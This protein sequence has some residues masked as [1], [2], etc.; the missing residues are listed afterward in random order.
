MEPGTTSPGAG[1]A[2]PPGITVIKLGGS[3]ITRKREPYRLRRKVLDRLAREIAAGWQ[4]GRRPVVIIHGA[5]SFGHPT[6]RA[7]GLAKPPPGRANRERGAALTAYGVRRLHLEVLRAL[8]D[9][10]VP[11]RSVPPYP[12]LRNRAGQLEVE[13]FSGEPFQEVLLSGGVPVTFGDVVADA[14]W[15]SSILSGD[16]LAVH[17]ARELPATRVLFVSDVRGV[18]VPLEGGAP[19]ARRVLPELSD[20]V[21]PSLKEPQ[22]RGRPDVTRGIRGKVEAMLAISAGGSLAGLISGLQHQALSRAIRGEDVEG[23]WTRRP[24]RGEPGRP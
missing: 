3:I 17:L 5:G 7:F 9:A 2:A 19:T 12:S 22:D 23:T 20:G 10:G 8:L 13:S 14:H 1:G 4:G 21:P 6:A 24:R 11:A 18:Y 16:T 15:G